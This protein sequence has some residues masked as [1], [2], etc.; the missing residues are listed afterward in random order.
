MLRYMSPLSPGAVPRVLLLGNGIHRA[1]S[2]GSWNDLLRDIGGSRFSDEE[3]KELGDTVPYP[4]LAVIA[5]GDGIGTAMR[6]KSGEMTCQ[7]PAP[8]EAALLSVISEKRVDAILT[9]NYTYEIERSLFP[10]FSCAPGRRCAFR[11]YTCGEKPRAE[12]EALYT[13]MGCGEG[14]V[15]PVWHIHGEAAKP[16]TMVLGHYWYGKLLSRVQSYVSE[17]VRGYAVSERN[18]TPFYPR[19]WVDYFLFGDVTVI[20]QGMNFCETDLWWLINCKKRNGR[21][22]VT[23][24]E[25]NVRR[26]KQLLAEAC[27]VKVISEAVDGNGY[28]A[29]Y[30]KL[31]NQL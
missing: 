18:G 26:D 6:E 5:A 31:I 29:Y 4:L 14:R 3:W 22:S 2:A 19:S 11:H 10:G 8:E 13:Y 9:T 23:Y 17:A 27:G 15:P 24:C 7:S 16:D 25:A 20:G 28:A 12:T 21:G 1:F 30:R